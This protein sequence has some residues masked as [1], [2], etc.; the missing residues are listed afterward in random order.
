MLA[1]SPSVAAVHPEAMCKRSLHQSH[2]SFVQCSK[3]P[4]QKNRSSSDEP[5]P[6]R[7]LSP[8]LSSLLMGTIVWS[9]CR[10]QVLIMCSVHAC[11]YVNEN[12]LFFFRLLWWCLI[13]NIF[14]SR[15]PQVMKFWW[16]WDFFWPCIVKRSAKTFL[17]VDAPTS[18]SL[19]F[20]IYVLCL[21]LLNENYILRSSYI[22]ECKGHVL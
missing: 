5:C 3:R 2:L 19:T 12:Q 15:K 17:H 8:Y 7:D 20:F 14:A 13:V 9:W 10:E 11:W 6:N 1:C 18:A 4:G 16:T 22:T 21:K